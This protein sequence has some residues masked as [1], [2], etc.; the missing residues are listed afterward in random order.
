MDVVIREIPR[1]EQFST[2]DLLRYHEVYSTANPR[3]S[4]LFKLYGEI[5][6]KDNNWVVR[7]WV[8]YLDGIPI[9]IA[10]IEEPDYYP[11]ALLNLYV[12]PQY[13][14]QG[15]GDRLVCEAKQDD[16]PFDLYFT[17]LSESLYLRHGFNKQ[18][19][20]CAV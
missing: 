6:T 16:G 17:P 12:K 4:G 10:S 7:M 14:R 8:A 15:I 5:L 20:N 11:K 9:G 13:R 2:A 18:A 1:E 3:R 19:L